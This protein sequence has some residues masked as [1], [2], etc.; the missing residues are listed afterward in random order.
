VFAPMSEVGMKT[1]WYIVMDM[2]AMWPCIKVNR[3]PRRRHAVYSFLEYSPKA[4]FLVVLA[5]YGI[6]QVPKGPWFCRKCESQERIARVVSF[7][8]IEFEC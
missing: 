1:L 6:V 4:C 8:T 3:G 5:C 7:N 2:D